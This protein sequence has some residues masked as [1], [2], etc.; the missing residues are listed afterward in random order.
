MATISPLHSDMRSRW[1][2]L[3]TSAMKCKVG[4]F[5]GLNQNQFYL[6]LN[7]FFD[8][9][10]HVFFRIL[11]RIVLPTQMKCK[12]HA[13]PTKMVTKT[14]SLIRSLV[15]S[16]LPQSIPWFGRCGPVLKGESNE[17]Y[18]AGKRWCTIMY[19]YSTEHSLQNISHRSQGCSTTLAATF[20]DSFSTS[21]LDTST[22]SSSAGACLASLPSASL[23]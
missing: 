5:F 11:V 1:R 7:L 14:A 2:K 10:V 9:F 13:R 21:T 4:K 17:G 16:Y 6:F 15:S 18:G 12:W 8:F 3:H 23:P 20:S 22:A 19:N